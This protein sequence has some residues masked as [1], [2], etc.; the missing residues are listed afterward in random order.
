MM[1]TNFRRALMLA[2]CFPDSALAGAFH[3]PAAI[4]ASIVEALTGSGITARPVDRRLKLATCP[5]A[6]QVDPP[7]LGAIAVRCAALNWR[8]R[9]LVD[10]VVRGATPVVIRRGDPVSV[11]FVAPGFSV[12][13]SGIAES[14][15]RAGERVRVRVEQ[16]ADPVMGEAIDVGSVRVGQLN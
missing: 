7:V 14:E 15:A 13:T 11:N 10:N 4:D 8:V 5:E 1:M 2:A 6:L 3:D 9:L 12:T 16:K